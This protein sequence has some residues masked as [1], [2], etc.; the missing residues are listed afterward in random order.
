[1]FTD[2]G[3]KRVPKFGGGDGDKKSNKAAKGK[4]EKEGKEGAEEE[5]KPGPR[6]SSLA[7]ADLSLMSK[8][9]ITVKTEVS[10]YGSGRG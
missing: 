1:M 5:G 8:E 4:G 6:R 2:K 9:A 3:S 10:S 7:S